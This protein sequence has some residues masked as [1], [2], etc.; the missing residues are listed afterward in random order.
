MTRQLA[1]AV[2]AAHV[3]LAAMAISKSAMPWVSTDNAHQRDATVLTRSPMA[4]VGLDRKPI[5]ERAR[6]Q[7]ATN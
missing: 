6:P 2:G 1:I 7:I 5:N 4:I 3:P